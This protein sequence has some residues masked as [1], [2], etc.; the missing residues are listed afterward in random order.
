[1]TVLENAPV[2]PLIP[3]LLVTAPA[4]HT[5]LVMVPRL[6]VVP[7]RATEVDELMAPVT[8]SAPVILTAVVFGPMP[9]TTVPARFI[10]ATSL[11]VPKPMMAL[12]LTVLANAVACV[13]DNADGVANAVVLFRKVV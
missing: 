11:V 5:P 3:P 13:A 12:P 4:F 2:V 8:A 6:F 10:S 9:S 7:V 1:M